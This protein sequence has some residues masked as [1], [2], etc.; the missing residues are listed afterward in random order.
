MR[1][2]REETAVVAVVA[3][4]VARKGGLT[5]DSRGK[6]QCDTQSH[7]GCVMIKKHITLSLVSWT[8]P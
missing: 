5:F 7:K 2:V 4:V 6:R 3:A 1:V 8:S